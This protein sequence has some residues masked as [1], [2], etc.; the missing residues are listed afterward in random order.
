M[1][2]TKEITGIRAKKEFMNF[3]EAI[4]I[5]DLFDTKVEGKFFLIKYTYERSREEELLSFIF[6]NITT[7]SLT[8]EERDRLSPER[9]DEIMKLGRLAI[10]RFVTQSTTGEVGEIILFHLLECWEGAVQIVNKMAL[11]TSGGMPVFGLDALH[12]KIDNATKVLYLGESKTGLKF[13]EVLK[14]SLDGTKEYYQKQKK[15]FD[16]NLASA[17]ISEDIP[18]ETRKAIKEYLNPCKEDL[19]DFKET[20]AIFLGFQ[21]DFLKEFE[22]KY[23]G[24]ELVEKVIESYRT[25]IQEY[26]QQ[27]ELKFNDYPELKEKRF[28]FFVI[29]FKELKG[30]RERFSKA[31]QNGTKINI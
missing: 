25:E 28:I 19:S 5:K 10:Q 6:D 12:F 15:E 7:Y 2:N 16:I 4:E 18:E 23:S 13:S 9:A 3:L 24:K 30:L 20:H 27:I 1:N 11:K 21:T 8:K 14:K 29:P 17:N 22:T 31:V 26:L